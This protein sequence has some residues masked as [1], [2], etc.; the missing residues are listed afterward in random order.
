MS[1]R[2][3]V[4]I[5]GGGPVGV[6]LAVPPGPDAAGLGLGDG[7]GVVGPKVLDGKRYVR[8]VKATTEVTLDSQRYYVSQ[9]LVGQ[10]VTLVVQ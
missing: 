3:Q 2:F 8:K 7:V 9:S 4:V 5:V 6:G 10:Q 1:K